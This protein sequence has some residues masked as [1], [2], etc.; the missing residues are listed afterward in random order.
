[1]QSKKIATL[2]FDQSNHPHIKS[3]EVYVT[4]LSDVMVDNKK[5]N[6][7]DF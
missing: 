2:L 7:W 1:M 5:A 3:G 6:A 4:L